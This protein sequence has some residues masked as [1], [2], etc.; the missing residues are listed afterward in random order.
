MSTRLDP[1]AI[2]ADFPTLARQVNGHPLIYFDN[3]ASSQKPQAVIEAIRV[4]YQSRYASVHR[5][6]YTLSEEAT[7][8]YERVRDKIAAF[9]K[10][11]DR[12]GIV[13][14]RNATE[15]INLVA[16][17][18]G[19]LNVGRGDRLLV[20]EM[21]HHSNLLPWLLLCREVGAELIYL[22]ITDE[23]RLDLSQLD[24]LL[25]GP[26][27]LVAVTHAS[28]VL[29]TVNPVCEIAARAHAAGALVL[30]DGA[31]SVPHLPVDVEALGCDFIAF[32]GHKMCGP[33]GIGVLWGRLELLEDMP[34]FLVG[35]GMIER[36]GR[37][38]ATWAHPPHKFEAGT[39]AIAEA[40]GLGAA[41]DYLEKTG[42]EVI[43]AHEQ[44]LTAYAMEQL[45]TLPWV[46][47][48]GPPA[49]ERI[50]VIAFTMASIHPHDLACLLDR[51]GIAIRAGLHCAQPLHEKLGLE[52]TARVSFYL[53]NTCDE[54]DR[55]VSALQAARRLIHG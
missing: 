39:P 29:G 12:R 35:G 43:Y 10:A 3:A 5:G 16:H 52:A 44:A 55:L 38:D 15:A 47:I 36:V 31:Q 9:I 23:G 28:N 40:I 37:T 17:S 49:G 24:R 13:F 7:A 18:W 34:P 27:K 22:P 33:T 8:A 46:H 26:V 50:G 48:V 19:R 20:T 51:E 4:F 42:M 45:S 2:R 21:E 30:V 6:I 25:D 32:S 14:T 41:V 54:V 1:L 11:P 53:Y